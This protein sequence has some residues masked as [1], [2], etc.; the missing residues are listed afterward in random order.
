MKLDFCQQNFATQVL[1][2]Q[3]EQKSCEKIVLSTQILV[4]HDVFCA[5]AGMHLLWN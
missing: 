3:F 4:G 2:E 1:C 5:T